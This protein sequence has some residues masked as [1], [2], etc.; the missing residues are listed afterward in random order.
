V[1]PFKAALQAIDAAVN[2]S[3]P[4]LG[5][6]LAHLLGLIVAFGAA[7]RVGLRRFA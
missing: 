7:A 4:G 5:E 2:R 1:F 6:S 3:S